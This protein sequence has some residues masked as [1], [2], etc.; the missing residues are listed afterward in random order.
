MVARGVPIVL[1]GFVALAACSGPRPLDAHGPQ[2][3]QA[4]AT[5]TQQAE[6][7]FTALDAGAEVARGVGDGCDPGQHNWKIDDP[8]D[9]R[10]KRVLTRITAT[11]APDTTA[12]I[13][14]AIGA[15]R[16][17]GC[18]PDER[19]V[20]M[21]TR[22]WATYGLRGRTDAGR[23]YSIDDLPSVTASCPGGLRLETSFRSPAGLAGRLIPLSAQEMV[24]SVA[25]Q[26][27]GLPAG[28][29]VVWEA[30]AFYHTVP[31]R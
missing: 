8:Y 21:V 31:A 2:A 9:W 11:D 4:R 3:T 26:V 10:C 15:V 5:M 20:D 29:Y 17:A 19:E 6:Q 28:D 24:D 12:V 1:A 14:A 25:P 18:T 23:P 27:A 7:L 13:A 30:S 22:Y 16:A